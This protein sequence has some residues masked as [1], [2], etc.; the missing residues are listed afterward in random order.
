MIQTLQKLVELQGLDTE[1]LALG[2]RMGA[3]PE[4]LRKEQGQYENA[5]RE[6]HKAECARVA[7]EERGR[8]VKIDIAADAAQL[9]IARPLVY[10]PP[11]AGPGW[12]GS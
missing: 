4:T 11:A 9:L 3:I 5:V 10:L 7:A 1:I 2:Q 12:L 6:L 8:Q